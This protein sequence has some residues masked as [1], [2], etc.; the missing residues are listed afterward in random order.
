MFRASSRGVAAFGA[1]VVLILSPGTAGAQSAAPSARRQSTAAAN[2]VQLEPKAIEILK[3]VADQ[4]AAAHTLS[5]ITVET[6]DSLSRRSEVTL[7]RPDKLRVSTAVGGQPFESY[8]NGSTMV[9]YSAAKKA[10]TIAKAPPAINE[11]LRDAYQAASLESPAIDL[12][13]AD[14][15]GDL[16]RGLKHASYAGQ[17]VLAGETTDV[18]TY[19]G[20]NVSVQMWV[21]TEDK[22][23]RRLHVVYVGDPNRV[24][25]SVAFSGWKI[26]APVRPDVFTSLNPGT[27]DRV[28]SAEPRPVGTSGSQPAPRDRPLTIHTYAAKYWGYSPPAP[29]GSANANY[30][31]A[32]GYYQSPDGY[33]YYAPTNSAPYPGAPAGYYEAPC[34]DCGNDWVNEGAA[35]ET[36]GGFNLSL[37]ANTPEWY[38]PGVPQTY[39]PP[40]PVNRT[41][42]TYVPGQIVTTL[43]VGCAAYTQ[44]AAFYLCGS[45]WFSGVYGPNGQLYFRV[46]STP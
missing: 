38:N 2:K 25:R 42:L 40:T 36:T 29:I 19:S 5:V 45:T 10:F 1:L 23:P 9:T 21:G 4:L 37:F 43:P 33:P 34:Y 41:N 8:C 7:Q 28:D 22:L 20:D 35:N 44:G 39:N 14:L 26:D 30:Y 15:H 12:I 17:S 3:A 16:I 27:G 32:T 24:R 18:V 6:V 31:G 13:L 46:I 11:C